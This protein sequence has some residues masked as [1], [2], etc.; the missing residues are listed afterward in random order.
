MTNRSDYII[1]HHCRERF[2][3]RTQKKYK[4]LN[5]CRKENCEQCKKFAQECRVEVSINRKSIDT[6]IKEM[7]N[8]ADEDRSHINNTRFMS[9]YYEKYGFD[10][11]F[12][13]LVNNEIVF[14]V[15]I[16][17]GKKM[18]VTCV[19]SKTHIA[20]ERSRPKYNQKIS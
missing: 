5:F 15:V 18:I 16:D 11:R 13:F 4:H 14:I 3:Q 7:V 1:T 2:L 8:A 9:W 17:E 20:G 12:E 10:K 6:Q 19:L